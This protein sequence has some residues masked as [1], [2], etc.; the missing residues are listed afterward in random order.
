VL[1][2]YDS[3]WPR[4]FRLEAARI[5]SIL[6]GRFVRVEH[7]GST[8]VPGLAAKPIIDILLMVANAADEAGYVPTLEAHGY[9]LR[10]RE[11][12]WHEHRMLKGPH[13][14]INLHVFSSG[15]PEVDRML[16]FRNWLRAN[17]PDRRRYEL[18]KRRLAQRDWPDVQHYAD[19]K[20]SVV[21]EII[22]RASRSLS[23]P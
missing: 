2:E 18:T 14:D 7:V 6:S 15:C 4:L 1:T 16:L 22:A 3:E 21:E 5:A 9:V 20:S 13:A 12:A 19:A 23:N 11:P 17:E 10:I 8:S